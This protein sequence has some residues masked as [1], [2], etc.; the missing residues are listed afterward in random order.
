M[1]SHYWGFNSSPASFWLPV[2]GKV[3]LSESQCPYPEDGDKN[4]YII[5]RVLL[6]IQHNHECGTA[7]EAVMCSGITLVL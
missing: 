1:D 6:R 3:I 2:L 5:H 7:M 4:H